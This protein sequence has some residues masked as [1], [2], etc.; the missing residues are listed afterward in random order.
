MVHWSCLLGVCTIMPRTLWCQHTQLAAGPAPLWIQPER[1]GFCIG[2]PPSSIGWLHDKDDI[3]AA[4]CQWQNFKLEQL[5]NWY[6]L[7]QLR[8]INA[9]GTV[10]TNCKLRP[11]EL[12][13][14]T[15]S[16]VNFWALVTGMLALLWMN[17][18]QVNML[19]TMH[20]PDMVYLPP[21]H[22][23]HP[24]LQCENYRG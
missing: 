8:T 17:W 3:T 22:L 18:K 5:N 23:G 7:L 20:S 9:T 1:E 14:S 4:S 15:R 10:Q 16:N 2:K 12:K 19:S 6:S 24:Q 11:N 21:N 13:V